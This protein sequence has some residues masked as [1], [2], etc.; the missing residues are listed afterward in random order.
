MRRRNLPRS[1]ALLLLLCSVP[2][3]ITSCSSSQKH[4]SGSVSHDKLFPYGTYMHK[5]TLTLLARDD[6]AE[7][8]F[9]FSGVV[10][11]KPDAIHVVG[12]SFLGTTAFKVDEDRKTGE[13]ETAVYVDQMKKYEPR[14][15]EYYLILR[16]ILVADSS[17][18]LD[19]RHLKVIRTNEKGFPVEMETMGFAK[20][21]ALKLSDFDQNGIPGVFV[22]EQANFSVTVQVTGYEI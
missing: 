10:Q 14:L 22:I 20:N 15:R 19:E 5:V 3:F 1:T 6:R 9:K 18:N 16:E 4:V 11:L 2:Y 7:K 21:A 12:L 17:P 8:K 13:I